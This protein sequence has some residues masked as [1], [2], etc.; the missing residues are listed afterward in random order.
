MSNPNPE[1]HPEN[2]DPIRSKEIARKRGRAGGIKAA[3]VKKEK[4]LWS[5]IYAEVLSEEYGVEK[6]KKLKSKTGIAN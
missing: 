6:G 4:K 2:L 5:E 1:L 3:K